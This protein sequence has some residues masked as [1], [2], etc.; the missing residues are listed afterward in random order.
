MSKLPRNFGKLILLFVVIGSFELRDKARSADPLEDVEGNG[1]D[2]PTI[3]SA[4]VTAISRSSCTDFPLHETV[5]AP[6]RPTLKLTVGI[7]S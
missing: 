5:P 1:S 6:F 7:Y 2:V 3:G 4:S